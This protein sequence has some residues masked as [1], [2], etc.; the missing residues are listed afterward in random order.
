MV[1]NLAAA[2]AKLIKTNKKPADTRIYP[3]WNATDSTPTT[4]RLLPDGNEHNDGFFVEEQKITLTFQGIKNQSNEPVKVLVPC[5]HMYG[6]EDKIAKHTA[7]FWNDEALRKTAKEY[8]R[9]KTY[10]MQAFVN[11]SGIEEKTPPANPIRLML[12]TQQ[13]FDIIKGYLLNDETTELPTDYANGRDFRIVRTTQGPYASYA[14]SNFSMKQRA[15]NDVE[16]AAIK[17]FGLFNLNDFLI[18]EPTPEEENV[19]YEM[20]LESLDQQAY[21]PDKWANYYKPFGLKYDGTSQGQKAIGTTPVEQVKPSLT[22]VTASP[23]TANTE[24]MQILEKIKAK[25]AVI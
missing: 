5:M 18:K 2:R 25:N 20:F 22:V 11:S 7:P 10:K 17:E 3:F 23:K 4:I 6:K 8:W 12:F 14:T 21:D 24:A 19:I 13:I 1:F 16:H 9:K 15:L